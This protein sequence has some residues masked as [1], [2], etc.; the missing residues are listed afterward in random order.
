MHHKIIEVCDLLEINNLSILSMDGQSTITISQEHHIESIFYYLDL[1]GYLNTYQLDK[2]I[3]YLSSEKAFS[4]SNEQ[5]KA[6]L[7][8]AY[9]IARQSG[10]FEALSFCEH[11]ANLNYLTVS[12]IIDLITFLQQTAFDRQFGEERDRL[13]VKPWMEEKS[14]GFIKLANVMG[15]ISPLLPS[16]QHYCGVGI[17]GAS[18]VRVCERINYFC[19]LNKKSTEKSLSFNSIWMLTGNRELS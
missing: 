5:V 3:N 8:H 15:V 7:K 1:A 6:D 16:F 4:V 18:S 9:L 11:I 14:D 19:E 12:D 2:A 17:M 13:Q 10:K